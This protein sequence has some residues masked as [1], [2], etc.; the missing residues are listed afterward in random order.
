[1]SPNF[2]AKT[3]HYLVAGTQQSL[4]EPEE[5][6]LAVLSFHTENWKHDIT[7][8]WNRLVVRLEKE[9]KQNSTEGNNETT[10]L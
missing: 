9:R 3:G 10:A 1:M 2:K 6:F 7:Q 4:S 5:N 8:R